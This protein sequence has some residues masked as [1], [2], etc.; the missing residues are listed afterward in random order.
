MP[1]H[2]CE[3]MRQ[4]VESR[5][6]QHPNIFDCPDTLVFYSPR[7]SEYGLIVHD[8][9]SSSISINYCPWCGAKLPESRRDQWFDKLE[10]MGYSDPAEQ[11]IPEE[12]LTD[13]WYVDKE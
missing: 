7:Y 3:L 13:A 1:T 9:G 12:F 5:C 6:D 2:C 4:Q 10:S 11:T 8:G